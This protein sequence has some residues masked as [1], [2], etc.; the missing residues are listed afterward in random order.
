MGVFLYAVFIVSLIVGVP[1]L[2]VYRVVKKLLQQKS[3]YYLK[4]TFLII[5]LVAL[6][7]FLYVVSTIQC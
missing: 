4:I 5:Y 2:L 6:I 7:S 1:L 3:A